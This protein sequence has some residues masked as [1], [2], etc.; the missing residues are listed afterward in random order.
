MP[1]KILVVDDDLDTLR[2]VGLMLQRQ[3]YQIIAA[4]NGTQ[5]ITIAQAEKPDLI[6][7]DVMM[8]DVDGYEVTRRLRNNPATGSIPIIMFTAKTMVDDKVLGFECGVDDYLTKPTQPRELFAHVKAVLARSKK[9]PTVSEPAPPPREKGHVVGVMAA[10]GGLGVSTL[11]INLGVSLQHRTHQQVIVAEFRP[12]EGSIGLELGFQNPE[13]MKRLLQHTTAEISTKEI[14]AELVTHKS[15]VHLLL[16][17]YLPSDARELAA[18]SH[19]EAIARTLAYMAQYIVLDLG[20]GINPITDKVLPC[21][22]ELIVVMEPIPNSITRTQLLTDELASRGFGEGRVNTVLYNRQRTE[23]QYSLAQVQKEYKHSIALVF[24]AAPELT[25]QAA[26]A[27]QPL[28][29]QHPD[30][31]TSQQFAK[32]AE[33]ITKHV[34]IKTY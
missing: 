12:G 23:M 27:N 20:P 25:Y 6:L 15:D 24:T 30:N 26:K 14:E 22:D 31:L 29:I 16:S 1:E 10:K 19:Y 28:V 13:G 21:C 34:R 2:L 18:G 11:A 5:A 33:N 3:G 8:P 17:S 32:L 7:L 9:Q 4:S